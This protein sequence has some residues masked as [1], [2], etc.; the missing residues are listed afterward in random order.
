MCCMYLHCG[1]GDMT[2]SIHSNCAPKMGDFVMCG[3]YL[4]KSD[5]K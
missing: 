2:L 4:N 5:Q 1:D 3:L